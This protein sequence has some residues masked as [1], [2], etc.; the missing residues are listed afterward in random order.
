MCILEIPG[1]ISFQRWVCKTRF[2]QQVI[3]HTFNS[4]TSRY[5]FIVGL[6]VLQKG[7]ILDHA[8]HCVTWD[9]ISIPM[10]VD[11][12]TNSMTVAP[13]TYFSC[14]HRWIETY[15]AGTIKIKNEKYEKVDP[16]TVADHCH[17]LLSIQKNQLSTLLSKFPKLFSGELGCYNKSQFTLEL[18]DPA[19]TPIFC[20]PYPVPQA[21]V[22]VLKQN[23]IT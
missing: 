21:H 17:H 18:Q 1:I 14:E 3:L 13:T 23:L 4:R 15:A 5:N 2:L 22:Q 8:Q 20:K 7:F 12:R 19:S 9:G 11:A 6:D 16:S 10:S